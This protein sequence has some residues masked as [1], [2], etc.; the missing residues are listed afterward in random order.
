MGVLRGF[1]YRFRAPVEE[2]EK[3]E[4]LPEGEIVSMPMSGDMALISRQNDM[5]PTF[6]QQPRTAKETTQ[7]VQN[8]DLGKIELVRDAVVQG[9]DLTVGDLI[10]IFNGDLE[11]TVQFVKNAWQMQKAIAEPP[12]LREATESELVKDIQATVQK[13]S[14]IGN[15]LR[16]SVDATIRKPS[17][18]SVEAVAVEDM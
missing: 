8:V 6:F 15:K 1:Y 5:R 9:K 13:L 11:Q 7:L 17:M 4:S 3:E 12:Q 16:D 2:G 18:E 10:P 14:I